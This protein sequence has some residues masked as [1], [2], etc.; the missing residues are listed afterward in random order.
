MARLKRS[1]VVLDAAEKRLAG[2]ASISESLDLGQGLTLANFRKAVEDTRAL[3]DQYNQLLSQVD[4]MA[5]RLTSA[6]KA[7]KELSSRMLNAVA[8]VYGKD[9]SEY[10][11]AGGVRQSERKRPQRKPK[12]T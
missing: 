3:L 8:A 12:E 5:N 6:E 10:E 1:S 4:E 11:M 7:L 9:S 2:L